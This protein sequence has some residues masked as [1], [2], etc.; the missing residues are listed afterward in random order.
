LDRYFQI[1]T[2]IAR[3]PKPGRKEV[4]PERERER[5]REK[6]IEGKALI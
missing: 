4:S 5:E 1:N 6:K 3:S 2:N